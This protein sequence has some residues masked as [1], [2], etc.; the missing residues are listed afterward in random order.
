MINNLETL[1]QAL[2][3]NDYTCV[4]SFADGL[5]TSRERGV[6]PLLAL[7]DS[8]TDVR[9][10][11]AVD[12]VVGRAAAF[13]Y[14]KLGIS[15]LYAPVI[16]KSAL[17]VLNDAGITVLYDEFTEAIIN[18]RGDGFCP[19]ESAVRE[20]SDTDKAIAVLRERLLTV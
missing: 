4:I 6:K 5:Y 11:C 10:A 18:R 15:A 9:G 12:K 20:I 7:L 17:E 3:D 14:V 8:G 2:Q 16:S 1:K 19:M 13:I